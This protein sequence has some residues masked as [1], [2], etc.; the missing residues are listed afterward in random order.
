MSV[1]HKWMH[2]RLLLFLLLVALPACGPGNPL[3]RRPIDGRITLDGLPLESGHIQFTPQASGG[4]SGGAIIAQ[5]IYRLETQ[6]G[7]PPGKYHV[8]IFSPQQT[9]EAPSNAAQP[10]GPTGALRLGVE[11]IPTKYNTATTLAAE[12]PSSGS[13]TFDF[14]LKSK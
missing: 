8:Q 1:F 4:V 11:L 14:N 5:G 6:K 9:P 2:A 3:G 7:L 12:V 10:N 13:T